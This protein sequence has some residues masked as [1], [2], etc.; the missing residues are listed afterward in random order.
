MA[1]KNP[2]TESGL[3]LEQTDIYRNRDVIER[4]L[5]LSYSTANP[6]FSSDFIGMSITEVEKQ[7]DE[8]LLEND[9]THLLLLLTSIEASLYLDAGRRIQKKGK[10]QYS[11]AI[12]TI[13]RK[14]GRDQRKIKLQDDIIQTRKKVDASSL[15]GS[16]DSIY[17][18]FGYR[19]W[20]AHGRYWK[21]KKRTFLFEDTYV[22]YSLLTEH[23]KFQFY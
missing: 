1:R 18:A 6:N 21:F 13:Y 12:I 9:L 5:L 11:T 3:N 15:K 19:H 2:I 20:L 14:Y 7:R 16:Y 8:L 10:D 4:S 22:L 17:Q 23:T